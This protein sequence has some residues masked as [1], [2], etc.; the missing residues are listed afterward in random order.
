MINKKKKGF[1]LV[2][3]IAALAILSIAMTG[4]SLTFNT[5]STMW[6]KTRVSLELVT[7]NQS[8][9]QNLRSQGK[10]KITKIYDL[11]NSGCYIFFDNY[12]EIKDIITAND[13]SDFK[14][15]IAAPSFTECNNINEK[16]V[17]KKDYGA[18]IEIHEATPTGNY[19]KFYDV[20]LTVWYLQEGEKSKS[21]NTFYIGR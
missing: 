18:L 1:T 3:L 21:E 12:D 11:S 4:I 20:K 9:A 8:I 10:N 14:V 17:D 13:Y 16:S 19:Y 6:K 15:A 2:E 7:D 5:S